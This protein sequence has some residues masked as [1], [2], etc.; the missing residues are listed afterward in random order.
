MGDRHWKGRGAELLGW[1]W[2]DTWREPGV[3]VNTFNPCTREGEAGELP[4]IW[5]QPGTIARPSVRGREEG[6][7]L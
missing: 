1:D 6:I 4:Y 7:T 2:R 5:R 3:V